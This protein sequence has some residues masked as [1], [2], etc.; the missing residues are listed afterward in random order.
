MKTRDREKLAKQLEKRLTKF[1]EEGFVL[2]G[3]VPLDNR[4]AFIEQVI[5][6]IRRVE[7]V[8]KISEIKHSPQRLDGSSLMFD[9]LRGAVLK[10]REGDIE[11]ACWLVFL[12]T[13]C[14]KNLTTG[15]RLCGEIYGS[16]GQGGPWSWQRVTR[17]V[18]AFQTWLERNYEALQGRF[19]NHRKYESIKPGGKGTG[20]VVA[21]YV[22]WVEA[23]GSH[24]ARIS[25]AIRQAKGD[26]RFA[27]AV[28]Y[29]EMHD[30]LR[31]GRIGCFDYLTMLAKLGLAPIEADS[32]YLIDNATGPTRGARLL[33]D[34]QIDSRT[35]PKLLDEKLSR[36]GN[37]LRV[38]MQ[39][40]EDSVC[41]WQKSPSAY[42]LFR[43]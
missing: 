2:T 5:D 29:W 42:Q 28:L 22:S 10:A 9:P 8:R 31:F 20:A 1:H 13:H 37:A 40:L 14:G 33:F 18:G 19:G 23:G 34:G 24:E 21:S 35:S 3:V 7:Y 11:E 41:N 30:V 39:V 4:W 15:W 6:S 38:D 12:S 32:T 36:L 16:L 25:S 26:P 17:N 43:G 27:F